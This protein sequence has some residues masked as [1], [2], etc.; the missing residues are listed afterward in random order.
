MSVDVAAGLPGHFVDADGTKVTVTLT[1]PGTAT[2]SP[3]IDVSRFDIAIA[4]AGRKTS[5]TMKATGGDGGIVLNDVSVDAAIKSLKAPAA[6]LAGSLSL[7]GSA[8]LSLRSIEAGAEVLADMLGAVAIGGSVVGAR[9]ESPQIVKM[10]V[11]GDLTGA[12]VGLYP[13][14]VDVPQGLGTLTVR[15]QMSNSTVDAL[16]NIGTVS[17]STMFKSHVVAGVRYAPTD[18]ALTDF[19]PV[20]PNSYTGELGDTYDFTGAYTIGAV[21]VTGR[22][23]QQLS[24]SNSIVAAHTVGKATLKE[25]AAQGSMTAGVSGFRIGRVSVREA[26]PNGLFVIDRPVDF[27]VRQISRAMESTVTPDGTY[28]FTGSASFSLS[29]GL[30]SSAFA[31][32]GV[33]KLGSSNYSNYQPPTYPESIERPVATVTNASAASKITVLNDGTYQLR[34]AAGTSLFASSDLAAVIAHVVA[35][36]GKVIRQMDNVFLSTSVG[37]RVTLTYPTG[38]TLTRLATSPSETGAV[39]VRHPT[40]DPNSGALSIGLSSLA[41]NGMLTG[42]G[43]PHIVELSRYGEWVSRPMTAEEIA[44]RLSANNA[45]PAES[46]Y[47]EYV[48]KKFEVPTKAQLTDAIVAA[49][50]A[51]TT[52]ASALTLLTPTDAPLVTAVTFDRG[53]RSVVSLQDGGVYTRDTDATTAG[54]IGGPTDLLAM[55]FDDA[56]TIT[57]SRRLAVRVVTSGGGV[58]LSGLPGGGTVVIPSVSRV[59]LDSSGNLIASPTVDDVKN[60]I[61]AKGWPMLAAAR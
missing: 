2:V 59:V 24:F 1:G 15:G 23:S 54:A 20:L 52:H 39:T 36:P 4:G 32:A 55:L 11:G 8:S 28:V 48:V 45:T 10:T 61:G 6:S 56:P 34:D 38:T 58:T 44:E 43:V 27:L 41:Y 22:G 5:L 26:K 12:W 50:H 30:S 31:S 49:G 16:T 9:I 57:D 42:S 14:A 18:T 35:E 47:V 46:E 33:L 13:N 7:P 51:L 21:N 17:A 53:R 19:A 25:V 40:R 29:N 37:P 3:S 60:A